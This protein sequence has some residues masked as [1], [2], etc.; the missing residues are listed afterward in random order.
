[1][2]GV[3]HSTTIG[4]EEGKRNWNLHLFPTAVR[5]E[6]GPLDLG[7]I[8]TG[9]HRSSENIGKGLIQCSN[10]HAGPDKHRSRSLLP[11]II[12]RLGHIQRSPLKF[13]KAGRAGHLTTSNPGVRQ[14]REQKL[15]AADAASRANQN[16]SAILQ[17]FEFFFS[18]FLSSC[19]WHDRTFPVLLGSL[20]P[21]VELFYGY[22]RSVSHGHRAI[23]IASRRPHF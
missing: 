15:T 21:S 20:L 22:S 4:F 7:N 2:T 11:P 9:G 23:K 18:L 6:S 14:V 13:F 17:I 8:R 10:S 1:M 3:D 19:G 5:R 16:S 12:F